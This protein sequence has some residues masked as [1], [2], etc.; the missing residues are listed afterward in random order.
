MYDRDAVA[1]SAIED[2]DELSTRKSN[3]M[4]LHASQP[5]VQFP[6]MFDFLQIDAA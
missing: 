2:G 6:V 1:G 4:N 3:S 5:L